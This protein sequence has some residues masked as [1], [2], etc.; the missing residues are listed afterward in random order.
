M[1]SVG[2][3]ARRTAP[4]IRTTPPSNSFVRHVG[5]W[6]FRRSGSL[7]P[8]RPLGVGAGARSRVAAYSIAI[9]FGVGISFIAYENHQPFRHTVLAVVRCSRVAGAAILGAI[10][11][12]RTFARTYTSDEERLEAYSECHLRSAN[13]VLRALLA[14]GGVFIKLGQHVASIVVLPLEW[15][16]TM[17]PLQDKCDPTPYED[18]NTLFVSDMGRP[19]SEIFD[20]FNPDPIGVASLAQVHIAHH[21]ETGKTVAVKLQH[22]HLL[23]FSEID[24]EMVELTLGWIKRW[25]PEFEFTWLGEE[26]RENLPKELDFTNEARN[27]RM[28]FDNF[29]SSK[30]SLYIPE[31]ISADKRVLIM[32]FIEGAR[33][34]DLEYLAA[35]NID[36][37]KVS[38]E[39]SRIFSQMVYLDGWFHAD[40]HPGNLLIRPRPA[41]SRSPYNFEIV[42]LDHGLYFDLDR[43]LRINYS[44]LWLALIAPATPENNADRRKYAELVGNVGPDQYPIFE[45]ALTGRATMEDTPRRDNENKSSFQRA[46]SMLEQLPQTDQEVEALRNAVMT[47]EGLLLSVFDILR[48]VPRRVLMVFKLNDLTRSLDHALATTHSKVRVFV[49]VAKYCTAAV[50]EDER[51][52]IFDG[53]RGSGLLSP[54]RLA[55][56]F[57]AWWRFERLYCGLVVLEWYMDIQAQ[58]R[59]FTAWFRGLYRTGFEGAHKAAAGLA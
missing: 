27:A 56:Y 8:L 15:R 42:L 24:M 25:F 35:H 20:Y 57:G 18:V 40:P 26:M 4:F 37:N 14:N 3:Y 13:R 16:S 19:L 39:L 10:D 17:R 52:T 41:A 44:K 9:T 6:P 33:V 22:P 5:R 21:R 12:K 50:W 23:E 2:L 53:M 30:T 43:T 58:A 45:A 32:E 54:G 31:V 51:Q 29:K 38:L 49:V 59:K 55:E 48:K 11:Y 47:K 7:P 46:S 36:R 28:A 1:L 34:D